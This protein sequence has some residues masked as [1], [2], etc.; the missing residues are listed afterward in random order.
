MNV[1]IV[2]RSLDCKEVFDFKLVYLFVFICVFVALIDMGVSSM[3]YNNVSILSWSHWT[4]RVNQGTQGDRE[5]QV[6][7]RDNNGTCLEDSCTQ[8]L[9]LFFN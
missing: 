9:E 2:L 8:E 4:G 6:D 3:M 1:Y 5:G 7:N